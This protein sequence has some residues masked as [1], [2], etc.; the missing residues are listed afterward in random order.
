MLEEEFYAKCVK[1]M[2]SVFVVSGETLPPQKM[3]K[4]HFSLLFCI[5]PLSAELEH[6]F[7][8]LSFR[9]VENVAMYFFFQSNIYPVFSA[10]TPGTCFL[11]H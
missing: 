5:L 8:L 7:C 2:P 1:Y 9:Y 4:I 3:G 6:L 10:S 11:D